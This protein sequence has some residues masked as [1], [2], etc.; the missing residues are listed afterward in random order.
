MKRGEVLKR[1]ELCVPA[2]SLS[3]LK[4]AVDSGAD[5]VY[6]G[7]NNSTNLRNF[8]GLNLTEEEVNE[9]IRYAHKRG[10]KVYV[11]INSYPQYSELGDSLKA[12]DCTSRS[13]ADAIIA[14]DLA[15]LS[16]IKD[17]YPYMRVHLSVQA[18]VS[19]P[20][21]IR[22]Y[23]KHFSI[24]RVTLPRILTLEE[25]R[26][27]REETNIELEVFALGLLCINC[28][29]RC[30]LSSYITG[31]SINT[32][33][34]CSPP[35][36]LNFADND[37]LKVYSNGILLNEYRKEEPL[38]YPTP[39]KGRYRNLFTDKKDYILQDP[40]SLNI[41]EILSVVV[42]SGIN[43]LKIEGRQR[44][45]A[46]VSTVTSIFREALDCYYDGLMPDITSWKRRLSIL[47]EG[48]R[49]GLGCY[50]KK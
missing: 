17:R 41:L 25:I 19:N 23:E 45:P 36:F 6:L 38:G 28:E 31:E 14:S 46:Y 11:T 32:Y 30:F 13:D 29:G 37:T 35:K 48:L 2:G 24:K 50:I 40:E 16:Y 3:A 8:P 10:K 7:F 21:A 39:C 42:E 22:F 18:G 47:F 4:A 34:A 9:G 43:T 49:P 27:L 44:S 20:P 5:A 26:Y 12:V 15:V 33:G 1:V